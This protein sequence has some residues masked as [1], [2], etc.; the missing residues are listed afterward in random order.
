MTCT[1]C[2]GGYPVS[3][4]ANRRQSPRGLHTISTLEAG[5]SSDHSL[6]NAGT[7]ADVVSGLEVFVDVSCPSHD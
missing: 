3:S 4:S 5:L 2:H 6:M 1:S 7:A